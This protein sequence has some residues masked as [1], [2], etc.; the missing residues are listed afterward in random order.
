[1]RAI[2][3]YTVALLLLTVYGGEVCPLIDGLTFLGW[4]TIL[5]GAFAPLA[6]LKAFVLPR[7]V[8]RVQPYDRP[9]RQFLA[10]FLMFLAAGTAIS[11][12]NNIFLNFPHLESGLKVVIGF[13]IFGYF[14][15]LDLALERER[16][17]GEE[18]A[19]SGATPAET[20]KYTSLTRKF[21]LF[22]LAT[23]ALVGAVLV[24]IIVKDL[25]W[26]SS[27]DYAEEGVWATKVILMEISFILL[28]LFFYVYTVIRSYTRNIRLFFGN[29]INVLRRVSQGR[30]DQLAPAVTR[31]EFGEI[32]VHTNAMID[33][34]R[35]R[36]RIKNAFGKAVSPAI[37]NRLME[38][39]GSENALGGSLQRLIILFCDIRNF[40]GRAESS[41]P[42]TVIA[43][44][45]SWFAEAVQSI[46][47]HGGVVDK[48]IGD[49]ILAVFGLDGDEHACPNKAAACARDLRERLERL[50]PSLSAPMSIGVGVHKGD[51]LA[52]VVGSPERLEFT[53]IG[54]VVNAAARIE[55]MTRTLD[56]DILVS[57]AVWKSLDDAES[58][59]D[60]GEQ[61]L[62]GKASGIRLYGM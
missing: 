41:S 48:F 52:G 37:A 44:L 45:N 2:L 38:L 15:G 22:A 43:D 34:L 36:E 19:E 29:E 23:L 56:S 47:A 39:E 5:V 25:L 20:F 33:G 24:L 60:H 61:S 11:L 16:V 28:V 57:E 51:V 1:M 62:K 35:E 58:W 27:I 7:L 32:A 17:T 10:E 30:L 3:H 42:Q 18:I 59:T 46:D 55:N 13:V 9:G 54:D 31:D 4:G 26:L 14:T 8:E 6:L 12:Y 21:T 53:V 50:N 40:T 49:G